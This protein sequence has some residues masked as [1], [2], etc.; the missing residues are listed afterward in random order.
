MK[1]IF[2]AVK[3]EP[4][5][6]FNRMYS[7]LKALLGKERINWVNMDNIHLTLVFL[8][9]TDDEMINVAGIVLRQKCTGFSNFSF[10]L[11]G[12]GV[13]RNFRDARVIWAGIQDPER[14]LELNKQI[15]SGLK[16]AGFRIEERQ[17]SPHV[18]LG[19]IKSITDHEALKS[20][21]ERYRET[22][23]QEVKVNEVILFESILKPSGPVY[24]PL[25]IFRLE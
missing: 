7:S 14:L 13:F 18:T 3:T 21:I 1:R 25:G 22:Y 4:S 10:T 19:R 8:G 24:R 9:D 6:E 2:I 23:L 12:T 20:A 17:F 15:V 16:D 11:S 5:T